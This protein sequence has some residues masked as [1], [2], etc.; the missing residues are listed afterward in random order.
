MYKVIIYI[1]MCVCVFTYTLYIW[2]FVI[3]CHSTCA[4]MNILNYIDAE[5]RKT[6]ST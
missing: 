4:C 6:D 2:I 5:M 3:L 1:Y